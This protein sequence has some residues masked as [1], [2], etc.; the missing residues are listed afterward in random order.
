MN[1]ATQIRKTLQTVLLLS[2]A[3]L[4][5]LSLPTL[6]LAQGREKIVRVGWFESPFNTSDEFGR[7]SGSA[8]DYQQKIAAYSGW[9]YE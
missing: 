5:V 6:A 4:T 2:L 3:L 9:S 7:R 1:P 8:Y